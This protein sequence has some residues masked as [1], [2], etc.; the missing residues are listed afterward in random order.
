MHQKF[1]IMKAYVHIWLLDCLLCVKKCLNHWNNYLTS[2]CFK[3]CH[4]I[5]K[6]NAY[7]VTRKGYKH[8]TYLLNSYR[9]PNTKL[10]LH[11]LMLPNGKRSKNGFCKKWNLLSHILHSR[12]KTYMELCKNIIRILFCIKYNANVRNWGEKC[13]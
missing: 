3:F 1:K 9:F 6:Q 13:E 2:T 8:I 10:C 5:R 4:I 11:S 7:K 12:I